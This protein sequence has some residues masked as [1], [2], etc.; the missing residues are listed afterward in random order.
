VSVS[1]H[2]HAHARQAKISPACRLAQL[3]SR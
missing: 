1:D 2:A 3:A